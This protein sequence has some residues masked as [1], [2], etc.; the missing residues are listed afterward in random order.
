[1]LWKADPTLLIALIA[2]KTFAMR[3]EYI[4]L[5]WPGAGEPSSIF[6]FNAGLC[7]MYFTHAE[8]R[9]EWQD[10][11]YQLVE[12]CIKAGI[13]PPERT[14]PVPFPSVRNVTRSGSPV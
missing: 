9:K 12:A 13:P 10:V 3:V 6:K 1:M 2:S 8:R 14:I 7:S 4:M 5:F 11:R